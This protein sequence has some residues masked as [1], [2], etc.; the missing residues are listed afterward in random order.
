MGDAV[1][2]LETDMEQHGRIWKAKSLDDY[3]FIPKQNLCLFFLLFLKEAFEKSKWSQKITFNIF[4]PIF[5][6]SLCLQ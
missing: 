1:V 3:D 5:L 2:T 6:S 4:Y